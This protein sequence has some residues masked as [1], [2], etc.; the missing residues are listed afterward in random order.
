[1]A[2]TTFGVND[3]STVKIW[4][5]DLSIA[6]R[7]TLEIAPL[8]GEDENS[9]IHFKNET[10]K[11]PGDR[12]RFSLLARLTGDGFTENETALGNAEALSLYT[13]DV[14]INEL[15]NTC[16]P[17]ANATID[18][19]R[20]VHD[21]RSQARNI[22]AAWFADRMAQWFFN[23]VCGNTAETRGKYNGF[24]MPTAPSS[25]R[26]VWAGSASNDQ[27]LTSSDTFTLDLLLKA[28]EKASVG[29]SMVRPLRIKNVGNVYVCY[30]HDYQVRALKSNFSSGQWGDIQKAA[31]QG[32]QVSDNPVFT[33]ALGMYENIVLRR[34]QDVTTGVNSSTGAT[35]SNVRRAVL[36]GAQACAFA[37]G[38]N[39]SPT[40]YRWSEEMDDHGRKL[41]IGAWTI[42]GMKKTVFNSV[43]YGVVT[44]HTYAAAA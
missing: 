38:Q 22:L 18:N 34:S 29:S 44:I 14:V 33:G 9:I 8:I 37:C 30:L 36:L 17:P 2:Y 6:A 16:S 21:L 7:D 27:G 23:Q 35:V 39:S 19:Q 25:T 12:I 10:K 31:M 3:A 43:D 15:G 41:E 42:A 40:R 32:G 24:N 4:A 5:K 20:I 28:R 1:M 11:G 26:A 13:D